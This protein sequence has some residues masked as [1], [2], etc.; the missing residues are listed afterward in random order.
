MQDLSINKSGRCDTHKGF[1]KFS[2]DGQ[3]FYKLTHNIE[4]LSDPFNRLKRSNLFPIDYD[5]KN[6]SESYQ[7][8]VEVIKKNDFYSSLLNAPYFPI[9][10]QDECNFDIGYDLNNRYLPAVKESFNEK[11]P[12]SKFKAVLQGDIVLE[13]QISISS[14]TNYNDF[15]K[16]IKKG[17]VAIYFPQ[18]FQEFDIESQRN[19]ISYLP[20]CND[21]KVCLSGGKDIS[22]ALTMY[23]DMLINNN[24]YSPILC[25]S[26]YIHSDERMVLLYKS[27]GPHLEFWSMTQM[28]T[29]K[30]KQV[31]EQWA[32]GITIFREF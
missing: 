17:V 27:Y 23:P 5:V 8:L 25:L 20:K 29:P 13:K 21:F 31:S 16:A 28:L 30:T 6:L 14:E 4:N 24:Y 2:Q 11:Y 18:A 9:F 22:V 26:S 1:R 32:G 15:I 10:L 19:L 3:N 7:S 12:Q